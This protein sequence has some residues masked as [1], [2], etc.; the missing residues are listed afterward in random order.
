[1]VNF[2]FSIEF[3]SNLSNKNE[4]KNDSFNFS[5]QSE[6]KDNL[7]E[8]FEFDFEKKQSNYGFTN[9]V[10]C[11]QSNFII[12]KTKENSYSKNIKDL[13]EIHIEINNDDSAKKNKLGRPRKMQDNNGDKKHNKNSYDNARKKIFNSCKMS[14]YNFTNEYIQNKYGLKLHVPTIEKQIGYSY[15]N[16]KKFI[17]KKIYDIF[18][19]SSPKR[20]KDEIKNNREKYNHNKNIINRLLDEEKSDPRIE[21]KI[22]NIIFN[23]SFSDFLMAYLNDDKEIKINDNYTIDLKGFITFNQSF[24]ERKNRYTQAQKNMFRKNILDIIQNKKKTH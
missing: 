23:L 6:S 2:V 18:C 20:V 11:A 8:S 19:D 10:K 22:L 17:Q 14:I 7:N 12:E 9:I 5:D 1:M 13:N 3:D 24:N 21:I 15:E 16:I 4:F